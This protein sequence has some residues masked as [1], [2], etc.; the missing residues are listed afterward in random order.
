MTQHAANLLAEALRLP[1]CDRS[2][3]AARLIESLDP[4]VEDDAEA[5][6]SVEIQK[7]LEELRTG[8]VQPIPWPEARRLILEESDESAEA[9]A[10]VPPDRTSQA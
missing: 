3:L 1:E 8:Q 9:R 10:S 4:I 2:E 6:W 5:A 7:R